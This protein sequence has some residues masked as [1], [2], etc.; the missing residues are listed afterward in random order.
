M[1][2]LELTYA[3]VKERKFELSNEEIAF[4]EKSNFI[5]QNPEMSYWVWVQNGLISSPNNPSAN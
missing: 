5:L 3:A 1:Y 2:S 4:T